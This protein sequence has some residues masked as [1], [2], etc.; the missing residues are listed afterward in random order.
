M[1]SPSRSFFPARSLV[2]GPGSGPG[3]GKGEGG[4]GRE[5]VASAVSAGS[6]SFA[7]FHPST[8][9]PVH[10]DLRGGGKKKEGGGKESRSWLSPSA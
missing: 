2:S 9:L 8:F 3:R 5:E 7:Q 4:E 1:S 10:L 6:F